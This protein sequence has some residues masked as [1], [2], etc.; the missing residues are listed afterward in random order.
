MKKSYKLN[1]KFLQNKK[2]YQSASGIT[3]IA[4]V[5]TIIVLLILAGVTIPTIT[6]SENAIEKAQENK[7]KADFSNERK[8]IQLAVMNSMS[9]TYDIDIEKLKNEL[10]GLVEDDSI[11]YITDIQT[12]YEVI[13]KTGQLY[14]INEDSEVL[15]IEEAMIKAT[16][17]TISEPTAII[18]DGNRIR[19][20]VNAYL[21]NSKY[22]IEEIGHLYYNDEIPYTEELTLESCQDGKIKKASYLD[23]RN[24]GISQTL[25][26]GYGVKVRGFVIVSY[27][28][29]TVTIYTKTIESSYE[30]LTMN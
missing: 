17:L 13:G 2:F 7:N 5:V 30:E 6:G 27:K 29:Y 15:T 21:N 20:V 24:S 3:L 16:T 18:S 25:D 28:S 26:N 10:N 4:L 14:V 19:T 11:N 1:L 23:G 9:S 12:E 22:K 8:A